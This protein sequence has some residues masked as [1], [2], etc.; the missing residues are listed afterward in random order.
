MAKN[1]LDVAERERDSYRNERDVAYTSLNTEKSKNE[2]LQ[3]QLSNKEVKL[4]NE[5]EEEN[6]AKKKIQTELDRFSKIEIKDISDKEVTELI[7]K[8]EEMI[9]WL[10]T[11]SEGY[12]KA[13]IN[14][15]SELK[16][17]NDELDLEEARRD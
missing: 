15:Y 8:F 11:G 12:K 7:D 3:Q 14:K 1:R 16:G 4:G 13:V 5:V 10:S 17:I 2:Q 9:D 6:E